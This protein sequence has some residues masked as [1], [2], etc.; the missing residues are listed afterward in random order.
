MPSL[1]HALSA[2]VCGALGA[3][4][5]PAQ[6]LA[7]PGGFSPDPQSLPLA[8]EAPGAGGVAADTLVRGCP[9]YLGEAPDG[10]VTISGALYPLRLRAS[11][12]GLAA[13]VIAE[14]GGLHRCAAASDDGEA[15]TR[16]DRPSDGEHLLW[17]AAASREDAVTATVQISELDFALSGPAIAD[18]LGVG[19]LPLDAPPLSGR[20]DLPTEGALVVATTAGGDVP[21]ARFDG[22]C[23]GAI[24]AAQP[25]LVV[26]LAA[27]AD[28]LRIAASS[29]VEATLLV[30]T[31]D[32]E[33]LCND[34]ADGVDPAVVAAPAPAGPWRIW[35]GAWG[36]ARAPAV[37][38]VSREPPAPEAPLALGLDAPPAAG[39]F[40]PPLEGTLRVAVTA[41]GDA[42][43]SSV[44]PSCSGAIDAA[45]PQV[46]IALDADAPAL[47]FAVES[48]GD[49]TLLVV[50]P[51]GAT[52]CNDDADGVNPRIVAAP[53]AAGEW[54]V[55]V[56]LWSD[57]PAPATLAVAFDP[58]EIA[59]AAAPNVFAGRDVASAAEALE[60]LM[61]ESDLGDAL[62][63]EGIEETGPTGFI[64]SG[65]RLA[66]PGLADVDQGAGLLAIERIVVS[67]VDL[68]GL[69]T[70]AGPA[71]FAISLEGVD[72]AALV[73]VASRDGGPGL[74]RLDGV[75]T[76]SMSAALAT[77]EGGARGRLVRASVDVPGKMRLAL[78]MTADLPESDGPSDPLEA[79]MQALEFTF[80]DAGF[81]GAMIA[82]QA[83]AAGEEPAAHVEGLRTILAQIFAD[84]AP[85]DPRAALRDAL[86]ARLADPDRHGVLRV[87]LTA[88]EGLKGDD[89][90]AALAGAAPAFEIDADFTPAP[91]TSP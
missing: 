15:V 22:F 55:W 7:L 43:A 67:D 35:A 91:Q 38:T 33:A 42:P 29:S 45:R 34:D 90:A 11:G 71:S 41:G 3:S 39:R 68:A 32:G 27:P 81:F 8:A 73:R 70:D 4:A 40:T 44:D 46:V 47:A 83:R 49:A 56:G 63:F 76:I 36:D 25:Q 23:S 50:G 19:A 85:G 62:A 61:T 78:S 79:S 54:R 57:A 87:R 65:V 1:K 28:F 10:A 82:A 26:D 75:E 48:G 72:Y 2:A 20:H 9:G 60:I 84:A 74:P 77:A 13:L 51:D 86:D 31:P 18:A 16:L 6:T 12:E 14:P 5:A 24:D 66:D 30:V 58:G 37:V 52:L 53:A 59:P 64:L 21:A 89:I 17:L 69:S 88:P 80:D